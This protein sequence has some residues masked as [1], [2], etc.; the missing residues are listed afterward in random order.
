MSGFG[1][2]SLTQT[3]IGSLLDQR[4]VVLYDDPRVDDWKITNDIVSDLWGKMSGY[5]EL[6]SGLLGD[7]GISSTIANTTGT[8]PYGITYVDAKVNIESDVVEHPIET[9]SKLFDT[10]IKMPIT[11]D[12]T[13]VMPTYFA[14]KIYNQIMKYYYDK[15]KRIILQTKYGVYNKLILKD[16]SYELKNEKIDRTEFILS[17]REVQQTYES[18]EYFNED[19]IREPADSSTLNTGSQVA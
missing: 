19:T 14:E 9:G 16:I 1:S 15:E 7:L 8:N 6:F 2:I 10:S 18:F 3:A 13:V 12:V 4:A 5:K 11:A 17:L